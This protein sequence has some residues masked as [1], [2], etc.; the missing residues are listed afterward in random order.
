MTESI[1]T[2]KKEE[3][4]NRF[5][6][7][8]ETEL[9]DLKGMIFDHMLK[10]QS[11]LDLAKQAR[12][13]KKNLTDLIDDILSSKEPSQW[14]FIESLWNR[15]V[16]WFKGTVLDYI[17]WWRELINTKREE[18]QAIIQ[19]TE[20]SLADL[21]S[22]V[23]TNPSPDQSQ[24]VADQS[25]PS[26][27]QQHAAS[28]NHSSPDPSR[29]S[30]QQTSPSSESQSWQEQR[31]QEHI[32]QEQQQETQTTMP[33]QL[34]ERLAT[35]DES[36]QTETLILTRALQ[37]WYIPAKQ[38]PWTKADL[39]TGKRMA[40][41]WPK[42]N[43]WFA[44]S[45]LPLW[46]THL[47]T[48]EQKA[49][50]LWVADNPLLTDLKAYLTNPKTNT[51]KGIFGWSQWLTIIATLTKHLEAGDTTKLA[52]YTNDIGKRM[53]ERTITATESIRDNHKKTT[54]KIEDKLAQEIRRNPDQEDTLKKKAHEQLTKLTEQANNQL[55]PHTDKLLLATKYCD[56]ATL[57]TLWKQ[58]GTLTD[59]LTVNGW[60]NEIVSKRKK[61]WQ[62][63]WKV[64]AWWATWFA[65]IGIG[66]ALLNATTRENKALVA[67]DVWLGMIPIVGGVYDLGA[68]I[69]WKDITG[70]DLSA[71][72]RWTRAWFGVLGLI[73][74][75]GTLVK[76]WVW[77]WKIAR[78]ASI[79]SKID[80]GVRIAKMI[81]TTATYSYLGYSVGTIAFDAVKIWWEEA[82]TLFDHLQDESNPLPALE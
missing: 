24:A 9:G 15:V 30:Q 22:I 41:S 69:S 64:L 61:I 32:S 65:T 59:L 66:I 67:A 11:L 36:M 77:V 37:L 20:Q 51:R 73:P 53:I 18:T 76:W 4:L 72:E 70:S 12:D 28:D 58:Y 7:E 3:I 50:K 2:R 8:I 68:A 16:W 19:K 55:K 62:T 34:T 29:Q 42:L 60:A 13:Q 25:T 27:Q 5:V 17:L 35:L 74:W 23:I 26:S 21:G 57:T 63:W 52:E 33:T 49:T 48:L 54:Q 56:E 40:T 46:K 47:T 80:K 44:S 31:G 79:A 71:S 43:D 10:K 14:W 38:R 81:G 82:Q 1:I 78:A 75:V 45:L 39:L 6:H